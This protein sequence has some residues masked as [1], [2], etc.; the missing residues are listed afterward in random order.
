MASPIAV[1]LEDLDGKAVVLDSRA[2]KVL[3]VFWAT[4]CPSC[5]VE[6]SKDLP[7]LAK[8]TGVEV[9]TVNTD[10]SPERVRDFVNRERI[11]FRV[12]R[13]PSRS[14]RKQLGASVVPY[15]A[16]FERKTAGDWKMVASQEA[17]EVSAV[18]KALALN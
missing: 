4:W 17:F 2:D 6:L 11:P 12:L 8:L 7:E 14:F 5:R 1:G 15:W 13:D 18:K 9:Q 10:S 3:V 16:V